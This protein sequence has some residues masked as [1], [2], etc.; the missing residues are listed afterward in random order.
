MGFM[1]YG[2]Y[3]DSLH[4]ELIS[5]CNAAYPGCIRTIHKLGLDERLTHDLC[6]EKLNKAF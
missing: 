4:M 3:I 1:R 6:L 5:R 2:R